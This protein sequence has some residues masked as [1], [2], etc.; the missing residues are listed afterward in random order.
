[1]E[2]RKVWKWHRETLKPKDGQKWGT[3]G[4]EGFGLERGD[5]GQCSKL[6]GGGCKK[7]NS[8]FEKGEKT[9]GIRKRV[10]T[11]NKSE[12]ELV[13][14]IGNGKKQKTL[15]VQEEKTY[16][17]KSSERKALPH[18]K[19]EKRRGLSKKKNSLKKTK[20]VQ[21]NR[22]KK[23]LRRMKNVGT[24]IWEKRVPKKCL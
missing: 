6:W 21:P 18:K 12:E 24:R 2:R 4:G 11:K 5:C 22:P 14:G 17:K 3:V 9:S 23:K 7:K 19:H 8:A 16:K 20:A 1:M 13:R 10:V 15:K